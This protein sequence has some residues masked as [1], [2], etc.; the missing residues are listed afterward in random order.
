MSGTGSRGNRVVASTAGVGVQHT[1]ATEGVYTFGIAM[2]S[3]TSGQIIP[4]KIE[5]HLVVD[6][7]SISTAL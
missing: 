7:E 3:W 6:T 5:R 1:L 2:Q 4:V